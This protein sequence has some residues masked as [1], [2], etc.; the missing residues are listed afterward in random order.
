MNQLRNERTGDE[1]GTGEVDVEEGAEFDG[2]V[3]F[4]FYV[5][6]LWVS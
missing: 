5:G 1:E 2:G 4:G 3:G 6:A